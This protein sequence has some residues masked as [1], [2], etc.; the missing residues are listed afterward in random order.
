MSNS[1]IL[2]E[3]SM[4]ES[5]MLSIFDLESL[6]CKKRKKRIKIVRSLLKS[7]IDGNPHF[8]AVWDSGLKASPFAV[9]C[10]ASPR[11]SNHRQLMFGANKVA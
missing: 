7:F 11:I 8:F 3:V 1:D 9:S 5:K 2:L 4:N 10:S 6:F